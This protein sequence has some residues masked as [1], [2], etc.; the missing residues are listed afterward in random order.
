VTDE[1][2]MGRD[3]LFIGGVLEGAAEIFTVDLAV[4]QKGAEAGVED[5]RGGGEGERPDL[6]LVPEVAYAEGILR[7]RTASVVEG[8]NLG[9]D[10]GTLCV[11]FR[12]LYRCSPV[13][14][15]PLPDLCDE[16]FPTAVAHVIANAVVTDP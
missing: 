10:L 3:Y 16:H 2:F 15:L 5:F 9:D 6:R 8:R 4:T 7:A 1:V 11:A 12:S 13:I 14:S